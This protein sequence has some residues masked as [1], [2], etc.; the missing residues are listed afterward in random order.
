M[1]RNRQDTERELVLMAQELYRAYKK[2]NPKGEMLS[3]AIGNGFLT[4]NNQYWKEDKDR[5]IDAVLNESG[6]HSREH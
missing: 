1:A 2:Y 3:I 5:P 6:F 4:I